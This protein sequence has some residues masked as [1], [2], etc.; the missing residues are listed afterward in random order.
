MVDY[1]RGIRNKNSNTEVERMRTRVM[2]PL[3][4]LYQMREEPF[5]K[6]GNPGIAVDDW[7][8]K[9]TGQESYYDRKARE[10]QDQYW[11][12]YY[13]NTGIDPED[14]KYP[15]KTGSNWNAPIQG[16]P[17]IGITTGKRAI[18]MLYGKQE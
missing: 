15:I 8:K 13:D 18:N 2:G 7:I 3:G 17:G 12:D 6:F 16:I 14:V 10:E 9:I 1:H 11:K 4:A 5:R